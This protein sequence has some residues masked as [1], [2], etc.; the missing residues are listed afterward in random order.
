MVK[1]I[2]WCVWLTIIYQSLILGRLYCRL[3]CTPYSHRYAHLMAKVITLAGMET[4]RLLMNSNVAYVSS[5]TELANKFLRQCGI[6]R[7][8]SNRDA[9]LRG[10]DKGGVQTPASIELLALRPFPAN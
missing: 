6:Q 10:D 5:C 3:S 9:I 7:T 4:V 8:Y 2:V 1:H